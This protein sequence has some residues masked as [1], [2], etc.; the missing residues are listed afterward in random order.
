M[1]ALGGDN[2]EAFFDPCRISN[3]PHRGTR[4]LRG[5]P[6]REPRNTFHGKHSMQFRYGDDW[7]VRHIFGGATAQTTANPEHRQGG[8][9][10]KNIGIER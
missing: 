9:R 6:Q 10:A 4:N 8:V 3:F 7:R 5:A 2:F 1:F